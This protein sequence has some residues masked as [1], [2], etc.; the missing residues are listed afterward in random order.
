MA[1]P[2][3]LYVVLAREWSGA[4]TAYAPI[5]R[6]DPD[7]LLAC[8]PGSATEAWARG[9]GVPTVP[10][11]HRS[12]RAS[13]GPLELARG[14]L[15]ALAA[16]WE[17]RRILRERPER[18]VVVATSARPG[19]LASLGALGLPGR[20][21][22]WTITD[23]VRPDALAA[24]V[25]ALA[26]VTRAQVLTHSRFVAERMAPRALVSPPGIALPEPGGAGRAPGLALLVG[27][28]S[29]TK[30]TDL[31]V[32]VALL[33]GE[34]E[35][36][37]RLEV[38][39]RAQYRPEDLALEERL[40]GRLREDPR[41]AR[42]VRLVGHD[43]AVAERFSRATLLLHCRPDE[44]FGM[45]LIEAMAAG[46]PVVAPAAA[47]PLEIVRDGETGLLYPPGDAAAAAACVLRVLREPELARRLGAAGRARV[48]TAFSAE[49]QV[50]EFEGFLRAI[51]PGA[52]TSA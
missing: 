39:G 11:T 38:V 4:E 9:L 26:R 5:L 30:R 12:I 32:E 3:V 13:A 51:A 47:G 8:P 22:V 40:R 34:Q 18:G 27:H 15:R 31:A 41:A 44:P 46:L 6:A 20:T 21:V 25:R 24:L 17:L 43:A 23:L 14:A 37:F 42:H 49:R 2:A 35:P 28:I 16:A 33:V 10:L 52:A 7:P 1:R 50:A 29:P 36:G 19:I 45:V 48:R